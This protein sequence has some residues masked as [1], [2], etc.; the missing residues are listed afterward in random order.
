MQVLKSIVGQCV[1]QLGVM[2]ALVFHMP[3]VFQIPSDQ[4]TLSGTVVFNT[5]VLMQLV[6]QVNF[7]LN[8]HHLPFTV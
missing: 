6:N 5:F 1:F 8:S 7:G 2:W 4:T 3:Q